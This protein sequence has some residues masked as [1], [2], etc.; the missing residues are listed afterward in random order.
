MEVTNDKLELAEPLQTT[1]PTNTTE[2]SNESG[3]VSVKDL[4]MY[5]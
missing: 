3:E 5:V 4:F 2:V 1:V